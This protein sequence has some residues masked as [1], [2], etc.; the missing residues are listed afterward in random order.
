MQVLE[1]SISVFLL[2]LVSLSLAF[3]LDS[4]P[5]F[6]LPVKVSRESRDLPLGLPLVIN[7][8]PWPGATQRA[9]D[10]LT[11][12][13]GSVVDAVVAGCSEAEK[14]PVIDSVGFG[15]HP[16]ESGETT[17]DAM[18]IDGETRGIGAVADLRRI[19]EA[20]AV[21]RAVMDH[22]QHT[23]LVGEAA[24]K[25]AVAMGFQETSLSTDLSKQIHSNWTANN[26]QPNFWR[27][28]TP[29]PR[30]S[31]G[32]YSPIKG[33][34]SQP[35]S[36]SESVSER[37]HD[38]IGMIAID[39]DGKIA[40]GTSTN[41]AQFKIPGRV[42]DTAI[43]G[44]GAFVDAEVGAA[45]ATG[46]GDVMM[47][48]LPSMA[49]VEMLRG[50]VTPYNAAVEALARI[51]RVFPDVKAGI[52]VAKKNGEFAGACYGFETFEYCV[53]E[54]LTGQVQVIPV[55]C[56]SLS[57]NKE[58]SLPRSI[59]SIVA[60][61]ITAF[62]SIALSGIRHAVQLVGAVLDVAVCLFAFYTI[63]DFILHGGES[64]VLKLPAADKW[65]WKT[66]KEK[67]LS[68]CPQLEH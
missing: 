42:G 25:F 57:E 44:S 62:G 32:P 47:R 27:N 19:K 39:G 7:T 68:R 66:I 15:N 31:C 67:V 10:V 20:V 53:V 21:A 34:S 13:N 55:S 3:D 33:P 24:T 65:E 17:L 58:P 41:G 8:W 12:G 16:D 36:A 2:L 5:S 4:H 49:A 48:F 40:A 61:I 26:C 28:V 30:Q 56:F 35:Q 14:D 64:T 54:A 1:N 38:T 51:A 9:W 46:D 37:N 6:M 50:G 59:S 52:V 23:M 60:E 29:D 22:T 63:Y 18:V 43:P 45:A 11:T